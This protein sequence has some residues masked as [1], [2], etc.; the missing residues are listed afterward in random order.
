MLDNSVI[1][2][3]GTLDRLVNIASECGAALKDPVSLFFAT[4]QKS[5]KVMEIG[6][7][8][9]PSKGDPRI[10]LFRLV[11]FAFFKST[12][13]LLSQHDQSG[14]EVEYDSVEFKPNTAAIDKKFAQKAKE[15]LAQEDTFDF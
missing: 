10:K 13:I 11:I 4:D 15:K 3:E 1:V 9:F 12:R 2:Q 14:F 6:I 7:I 5:D 8:R